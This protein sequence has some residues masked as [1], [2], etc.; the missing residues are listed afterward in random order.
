[1]AVRIGKDYKRNKLKLLVSCSNYVIENN[2]S[3]KLYSLIRHIINK[4]C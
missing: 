3:D 4:N 2:N 1:M